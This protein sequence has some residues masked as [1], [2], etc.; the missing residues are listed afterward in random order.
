MLK[1]NSTK[2][3]TNKRIAR[4]SQSKRKIYILQFSSMFSLLKVC[5]DLNINLKLFSKLF[6]NFFLQMEI[7]GK[8][9]RDFFRDKVCAWHDAR[10]SVAHIR[11]LDEERRNFWAKRYDS[12]LSLA[13]CRINGV[14]SFEPSRDINSCVANT[15]YFIFELWNYFHTTLFHALS[16]SFD[17]ESNYQ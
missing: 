14:I 15:N 13:P 9:S 3:K 17:L 5:F 6:K 16:T 2:R 11:P 1:E 8:I 12:R 7:G 4:I 10:F